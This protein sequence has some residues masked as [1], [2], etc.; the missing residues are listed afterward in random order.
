VIKTQVIRENNKP[1][2]VI[3]D[4]REYVRLKEIEEDRKDY[5]SAS[6]TKAANKKWTG[7]EELKTDLGL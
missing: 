3:M 5:N 4:Y 6:R 1:V 7:H 2:A